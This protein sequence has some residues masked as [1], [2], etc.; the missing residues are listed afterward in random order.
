MRH[1][2]NRV[3]AGVPLLVGML[4]L[5][6]CQRAPSFNI[7]GSFFPAWLL[8]LTS[9][10]LLAVGTRFLLLAVHLEEALSPPIV[11]YPCLA[12]FF[13]FGLWLLVFR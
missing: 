3:A 1:A 5:A 4:P 6:G 11:M 9:G 8:C 12:A 10:I 7:L 2:A 13:T